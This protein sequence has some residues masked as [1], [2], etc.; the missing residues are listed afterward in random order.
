MMSEFFKSQDYGRDIYK[1]RFLPV[2]ITDEFD[3][4]RCVEFQEAFYGKTVSEL[5]H[6]NLRLCSDRYTKLF[7][8]KNC[9]IGQIVL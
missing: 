7:S 1:H 2:Y 5:H 4:Y 3:F 8:G 6:G 9:L